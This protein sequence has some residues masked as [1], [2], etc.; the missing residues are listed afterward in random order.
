MIRSEV[1]R[2]AASSH[3]PRQPFENVVAVQTA[4]DIDGQ[5]R[6]TGL[7]DQGRHAKGTAIAGPI[8]HEVVAPP[9]VAASGTQT[10]ARAIVGSQPP[11][12][13]LSLGNLQ[14]FSTPPSFGALV[15]DLKNLHRQ[16]ST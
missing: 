7:V 9:M 14:A 11:S 2:D 1:I 8:R 6:A 13:W 16:A 10:D 12:L 3:Q 15:I 4:P 5:T